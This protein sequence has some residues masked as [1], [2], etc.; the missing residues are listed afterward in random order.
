MPRPL[1][2]VL[3][4]A[5]SLWPGNG[6][7]CRVARLIERV[8][9][10]QVRAGN[11]E[12][13]ALALSDPSVS[14]D[15]G[16][17][18]HLAKSSRPRYV[19][20]N[21]AAALNHSH[22]IYD[23]VGMARAHPRLPGL[24]RPYMTYIHGIEVWEDTRP[25]RLFWARNADMLLCNTAY[26]RDRAERLHGGMSQARVCHLATETDEP[27]T[28]VHDESA[29]PA[30]LMLGRIDAALY[31]G[32]REMV[33]AW[34]AVVTA[35]PAARLL[36]AGRG[37]GLDVLKA[38]AATTPAAGAIDFLGFVPEEQMPALWAKASVFALP[39][40]GEGF[41][42]VYIEAMRHGL[43]VIA[44]VHD[45]APE[46]NLDGETGYNVNLDAGG[47]LADRVITLLR[48]RD[49]AARMGAAGMARW[50]DHFRYSSFRDRF[51]P[52][53]KEFVR[54]R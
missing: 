33:A 1:P 3:L 16:L 13:S 9:V 47:E 36:I 49:L 14:P 30:V 6:G 24:R 52:L 2:H 54:L 15:V 10:E 17:P 4:A 23:F 45:A 50:R 22:F 41:G 31:K 25:D 20:R 29:P 44:S 7:I 35:L 39:S 53:L 19:A 26:T 32:H 40:R 27:S 43:P 34:P 38:E 18:V 12:A 11:L 48:D 5:E 8:L 42:L 51:T 37:P 46:V 21:Y 28:V